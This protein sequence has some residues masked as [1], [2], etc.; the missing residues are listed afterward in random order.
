MN[1]LAPVSGEPATILDMPLTKEMNDIFVAA[2]APFNRAADEW[3]QL[4]RREAMCPNNTVRY[5]FLGSG[6]IQAYNADFSMSLGFA[7]QGAPVEVVER[8]NTYSLYA[9]PSVA[10]YIDEERTAAKSVRTDTINPAQA[11]ASAIGSGSIF[12]P[13]DHSALVYGEA[14]PLTAVAREWAQQQGILADVVLT[15]MLANARRPHD[16]MCY[17]PTDRD[18]VMFSLLATRPD[19]TGRV[20]S[21]IAPDTFHR[22]ATNSLRVSPNGDYKPFEPP[23]S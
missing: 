1:H 18:K 6:A 2:A 19:Q 12:L 20:A 21:P 4:A 16:M 13:K 22:L 9:D 17:P 10:R 15:S 8:G 5:S 3:E 7:E 23:R 14:G 11:L